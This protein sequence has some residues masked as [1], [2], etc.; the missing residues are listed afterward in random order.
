MDV[1]LQM[2][3]FIALLEEAHCSFPLIFLTS[4]LL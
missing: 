4:S 1:L 3:M 2:E